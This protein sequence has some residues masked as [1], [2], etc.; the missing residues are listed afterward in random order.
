M[1]RPSC[2]TS[3]MRWKWRLPGMLHLK[4]KLG[5][6]VKRGILTWGPYNHYF[7]LVG[8]LII[9]EL[10]LCFVSS[11]TLIFVWTH[12]EQW[13][14]TVRSINFL[15]ASSCLT[16]NSCQH[17]PLEVQD[18]QDFGAKFWPWFAVSSNYRNN[19]QGQQ[20]KISCRKLIVG[21]QLTV[22][23]PR[24]RQNGG[25]KPQDCGYLEI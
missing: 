25:N 9:H 22:L 7:Q 12:T 5:C 20:E 10:Q 14:L 4:N 15:V 18:V 3:C 6:V 11:T 23:S 17:D 8:S 21:E 24:S 1:H 19:I 13:K 2:P 16:E